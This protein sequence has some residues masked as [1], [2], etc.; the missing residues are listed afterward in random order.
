MRSWTAVV[1]FQTSD[2]FNGKLTLLAIGA[3]LTLVA[4]LVIQRLV[5]PKVESR[6]RR[7]DRWERDVLALGELLTVE[8]PDKSLDLR[9]KQWAMHSADAYF[10]GEFPDGI[11]R[12]VIEYIDNAKEEASISLTAY[13]TIV[14][15]RIEWLISRII[16]IAADAPDMKQLKLFQRRYFMAAIGVIVLDVIE[17]GFNEVEFD[18][19]WKMEG[20]RATELTKEVRELAFVMR[21]PRQPRFRKARGAI[22]WLVKKAM[23]LRLKVRRP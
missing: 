1:S 15:T 8:L 2:T 12:N 23:Q 3:I 17:D 21:V 9:S 10:R 13:R 19:R 22:A 4:Q 18:K 11:P 14:E 7:E 20:E 6:K 16:S 5:V